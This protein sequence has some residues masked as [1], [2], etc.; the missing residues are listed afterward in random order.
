MNSK[1]ECLKCKK[2]VPKDAL[3]CPYCGKKQNI[4]PFPPLNKTYL[5]LILL[6]CSLAALPITKK[7]IG[8]SKPS[9]SETD[10]RFITAIG[11]KEYQELKPLLKT[12]QEKPE[13]I[14]SRKIIVKK[15]FALLQSRDRKNKQEIESVLLPI[16]IQTLLELNSLEPNNP[17]TIYK[18]AD[19]SLQYKAYDQ[20]EKY[21]KL[22][23][24]L[25]PK[26]LEA[27]LQRA[28]ALIFLGNLE[29]AEGLIKKVVREAPKNFEAHALYA[30]VLN[31]SAKT[32][33]AIKEAQLALKYAPEKAKKRIEKFVALLVNPEKALKEDLNLF[34]AQLKAT[35]NVGSRLNYINLTKKGA[36]EIY[37]TGFPMDKMPPT[38]KAL[39]LE[40][41]KNWIT[42]TRLLYKVKIVKF[43]NKPDKLVMEE[44]KIR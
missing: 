43:I 38:V 18:I 37:F 8:S 7:T 1:K 24:K 31:Q 44:I 12:A 30:I 35:P 32:K 9:V 25:K 19:I 15:L 4:T 10:Y 11:E 20:A 29:E 16:L 27:Y 40:K 26:N 22:Y 21:F 3:Y 28:T 5:I 14:T 42:S 41:V 2:K 23:I 17:D 34:A 13:D 39:F 6:L 33:E 36:L